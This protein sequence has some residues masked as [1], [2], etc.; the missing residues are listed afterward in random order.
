MTTKVHL[1][2]AYAMLTHIKEN[3]DDM[4]E[5]QEETKYKIIAKK[6]KVVATSLPKESNEVIKEY[7][8]QHMLKDPKN[9]GHKLIE[10]TLNHL[11]I[12]E[13]G[14]IT[15]NIKCFQMILKKHG[16]AFSLEQSETGR[17]DP[18]VVF[19]MVIFIDPHVLS[20]L[21]PIPT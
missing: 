3:L 20:S 4:I 12:G 15:S 9:T 18:N 7:S 6:A 19:P 14:L 17:V 16:K 10:E 2:D 13:D 11:K 8:I 1:V 21:S 5:V